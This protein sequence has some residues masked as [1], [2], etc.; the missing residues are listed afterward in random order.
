MVSS[1]KLNDFPVVLEETD[2][3]A[4]QEHFG[5]EIGHEG[6]ASESVQWVCLTGQTEGQAWILWLESSEIDGGKVGGFQ[7]RRIGEDVRVDPRCRKADD[8]FAFVAVPKSVHVG[9][10]ERDLLKIL[11]EP[12]TR[13]RHALFFAHEHKVVIGSEAYESDNNIVVVLL[14]GKVYAVQVWKTTS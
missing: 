4:V 9:M 6:D 2:L 12:T 7:I 8:T 13:N 3:K 10:T 1:L 5:A 11:G 14:E